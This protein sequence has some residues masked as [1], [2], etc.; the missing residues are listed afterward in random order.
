MVTRSLKNTYWYD[1]NGKY[2][3]FVNENLNNGGID[4]LNIKKGLKDEYKKWAHTYYRFYN[5]GDQPRHDI[6]KNKSDNEISELLEIKVNE[7]I[8]KIMKAVEG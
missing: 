3:K 4:N 1:G 7:I 2:S 8:S 6:F 5:D